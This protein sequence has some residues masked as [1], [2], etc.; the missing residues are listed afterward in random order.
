MERLEYFKELYKK[1]LNDRISESERAELYAFFRQ[2]SDESIGNLI[3]SYLYGAHQ[4]PD[5]NHLEKRTGIVFSRIQQRIR[6]KSRKL[7]KLGYAAAI[8]VGLLT[9]AWFFLSDGPDIPSVQQTTDVAPG[10]HRATLTLS[11]GKIIE[12]S[13]VKEGIVIKNDQIIYNDGSQRIVDLRTE[14]TNRLILT[15]PNGGTYEITLPDGTKVWLNSASKLIYPIHFSD[16]ERTVTI[17]GE[18][19][20]AVTKKNKLP[21]RVISNQ[22]EIQVLGTEFNVSAYA[23]E[24]ET[25]TTL[26]EGAVKIL[27]RKS[28]LFSQLRPNEQSIVREANTEIQKV[29]IEP[30]IA[31]K[32]GYF[33]F[34]HTP[35]KEVMRQLARWYNVEV[36][37]KV[38]IP[39]ETFSGKLGRDLTLNAALKL[40]N[41]SA[42][43][44]RIVDGN[45]LIVY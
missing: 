38:S 42:V 37:Y 8:F 21:F 32:K 4:I 44:V 14:F 13:D 6:P 23:E 24:I 36:V 28:G 34:K 16:V 30:S 31:W 20:F 19:Y 40:L 35:F 1:Y 10:G 22:Q 7:Y 12:L 43:Q 5:L 11:D 3:D 29:D 26:I 33:Y 27:N 45:K 9:C 2:E 15:T 18:A 41:V 25:R 39:E 17:T